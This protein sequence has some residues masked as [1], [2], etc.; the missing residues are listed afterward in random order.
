MY[1]QA[2]VK[3]YTVIPANVY[4]VDK[5]V[6]TTDTTFQEGKTYYTVASNVYSAATVTAGEA[7]TE[8]TYYEHSYELATGEF[9]G[10]IYFTEENGTYTQVA[11]LAGATVDAETYY[12]HNKV[13]FAG[14]TRNVTY[15]L[16]AVIDCPQE[17]VLPEIEDETH[18]CW[19]EIRLRHV[20]SFSSTLIVPA[21]VKVATQ[22]TQ[23]ETEGINMVD[24]HYTNSG[25]VKLWRFLNTHS[26]IPA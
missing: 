14:M 2:A 13:S 18:G 12:V 9:V 20:G 25:G 15:K 22:H 5:Y 1:T 21:G 17:Y 3:A 16:D 19:F 11:V 10:T 6:L 24:L 23:A 8:S 26:T 4:Y 7:V